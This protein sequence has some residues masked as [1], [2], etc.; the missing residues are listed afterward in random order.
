MDTKRAEL[1]LR[2]LA[3]ARGCFSLGARARTVSMITGLPRF[4]LMDLFE[5]DRSSAPA[6]KFPSDPHWYFL[7]NVLV[8]VEVCL[9][10]D[11]F[12]RMRAY[13]ADPGSAM[14]AAYRLYQG[15]FS[16]PG[17]VKRLR[18]APSSGD[19]SLRVGFDRAA[20]LVRRTFGV[21]GETEPVLAMATCGT[22]GSRHVRLRSDANDDLAGCPYCKLLVRYPRDASVRRELE[23]LAC[24]VRCLS[25]RAQ[26]AKDRP[27]TALS[28]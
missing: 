2:S 22:C 21:W 10:L 13:G 6:G 23:S 18:D 5:L 25:M 15:W 3:L 19:R 27:A 16:Q 26:P 17:A 11:A 20:D 7:C 24:R 8:Q 4:Y 14:V 28:T 9:I 1:H 12:D